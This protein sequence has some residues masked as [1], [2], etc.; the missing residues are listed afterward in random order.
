MGRIGASLLGLLC[1]ATLARPASADSFAFTGRIHAGSP[2]DGGLNPDGRGRQTLRDLSLGLDF[3]A[4]ED[5]AITQLGVWDDNGDGLASPHGLALYDTS[6]GALLAS[7]AALPGDGLL[8][9]GYRYF[10]LSMPVP[11]EAGDAFSVAVYYPGNNLD[12][13]GN[14]GRVDQGLEPNPLFDGLGAILNVGGGR[15]DLGAGFPTSTDTGPA[16]R[17][18]SG[19]FAFSGA[20]PE[21]GALLLLAI[22]VAAFVIVRRR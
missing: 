6:T 22:A 3:L 5:V 19:S 16:N 17:Y 14:S 8:C 10:P 21:P 18:H 12:S 20:V 11:L 1:V 15:Y 13:S 9:E 7:I 2:Q 4:L